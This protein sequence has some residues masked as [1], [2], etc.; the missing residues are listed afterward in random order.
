MKKKSPATIDTTSAA[1]PTEV[2]LAP[3][4]QLDWIALVLV[5]IQALL[6]SSI[7]RKTKA[8]RSTRLIAAAHSAAARAAGHERKRV[9]QRVVQMDELEPQKRAMLQRLRGGYVQ[10]GGEVDEL[11]EPFLLRFL[12]ATDWNEAEAKRKM[13]DA[14]RWR[15]EHGV[16]AIRKLYVNGGR[17]LGQHPFFGKQLASL[18]LAVA[19]QRAHDGDVLT[20]SAIG[21]FTPDMWFQTISDDEYFELSLHIFEYLSATADRLSHNERT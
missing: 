20:I 3:A 6:L 19:H 10:A 11:W 14:A 21:T 1:I 18:G 12:V 8:L 2:N 7:V 15:R 17:K 13:V 5:C 9:G 16:N 4:L